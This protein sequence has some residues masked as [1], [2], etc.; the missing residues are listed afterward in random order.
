MTAAEPTAA[1]A[2]PAPTSP[3]KAGNIDSLLQR[4][5]FLA[6]LITLLGLGLLVGA[7]VG[8]ALVKMP[9]LLATLWSV[10]LARGLMITLGVAIVWVLV[11]WKKSR[12]A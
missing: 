1:S 3:P 5:D 9:R 12:V 4:L 2:N 11:R 6:I 7:G 10:S 8:I